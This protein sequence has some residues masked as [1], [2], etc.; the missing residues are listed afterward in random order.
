MHHRA[1]MDKAGLRR[2]MDLCREFGYPQIETQLE[3]IQKLID[4]DEQAL[5]ESHD[6]E[7]MQN[8]SDPQDVFTAIVAKTRDSKASAYFL[9][10][11]QHLLLIKDDDTTLPHY[12]QL[13]DSTITDI[14]MDNKLN[15]VESKLGTSVQRIIAQLNEAERYQ[16]LEEQANE[17]KAR[18]VQLKLEKEALLEELSKGAD[19]LVGELKIANAELEQKLKSSRG[20]VELLQG[21]IEEQKRGYEEQIAQLEAQILELFR[22]LKELGKGYEEI[23]DNSQGMDRKELMATLERQLQRSNTISLLEGH[24][25]ATRRN[26]GGRETVPSEDGQTD[27]LPPRSKSNASKGRGKGKPNGA[28]PYPNDIRDSQFAD[29]DEAIVQEH[30]EQRIAAGTHLVLQSVSLKSLQ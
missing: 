2:I 11:L 18:V 28:Y 10:A 8:F 6:Q 21:R 26:G 15:G 29:A 27:E 20:T 7:I 13:I 9:S 25:D 12:F 5:R 16:F 3:L 4:A 19:G 23:V 22:M 30:L 1:D 17:A 14:V 24:R